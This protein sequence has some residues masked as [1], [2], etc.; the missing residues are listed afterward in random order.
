MFKLVKKENYPR[1]KEFINKY[2]YKV[3][4]NSLLE[5]NTKGEVFADDEINPKIVLVWI[6]PVTSYLFGEIK[7]IDK[8]NGEL[9]KLIDDIFAPFGK[10]VGEI[11]SFINIYDN[12][13]IDSLNHNFLEDRNVMKGGTWRPVFDK[14]I[15]LESRNKI[16]KK[17]PSDYKLSRIT[18]EI[19]E[20]KDNDELKNDILDHWEDI[21]AFIRTGLGFCVIKNKKVI[22]SSFS[23]YISDNNYYEISIK[24]FDTNERKRGFAAQTI[25]AYNDYC[26]E[27]GYLPHWEADSDN[28]ASQKFAGKLGFINPRMEKG[29]IFLFNRVDNLFYKTYIHLKEDTKP[30]MN[31]VLS[32]IEKAF[33]IKNEKPTPSYLLHLATKLASN[34]IKDKV[35]FLLEEF[36]KID[37]KNLDKF[38]EKDIFKIFHGTKEWDELLKKYSNKF[39]K[40]IK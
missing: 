4:T 40:I 16:D 31:F 13:K 26:L 2:E 11:G 28:I 33:E 35:I 21:D 19:L 22:S 6:K 18:N 32:N 14:K 3:A 23:I 30:D 7:N 29:C 5:G 24:T 8:L 20:S 1:I 25:I 15:Y 39:G 34:G 36:L 17:M 37:K 10:E 12:N 38:I 9:N 27:K